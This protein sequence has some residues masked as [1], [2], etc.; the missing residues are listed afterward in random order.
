[1]EYHP[2]GIAL[3]VRD[4]GRGF[5]QSAVSAAGHYGL[6]GMRERAAT[7]GGTIEVMSEPGTGTTVRLR[8][9]PSEAKNA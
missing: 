7:I 8:A 5:V 9:E 1:L 2:D 3:D 6:I 4:D